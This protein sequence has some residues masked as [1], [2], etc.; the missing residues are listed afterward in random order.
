MSVAVVVEVRLVSVL[1]RLTGETGNAPS[2]TLVVGPDRIVGLTHIW[3]ITHRD[4]T[5]KVERDLL[6]PYPQL[7]QSTVDVGL[8]IQKEEPQIEFVRVD[9]RRLGQTWGERIL[10]LHKNT[11]ATRKVCIRVNLQTMQQIVL[12][13]TAHDTEQGRV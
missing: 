13:V 8:G 9:R 11:R 4:E 5:L 7:K 1:H 2:S 6:A 10:Q 3:A 12:A